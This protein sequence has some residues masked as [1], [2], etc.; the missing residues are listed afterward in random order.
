MLDSSFWN[1][2]IIYNI[3]CDFEQCDF[4]QDKSKTTSLGLDVLI[5]KMGELS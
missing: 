3:Y 1:A 4:E 5:C 2:E